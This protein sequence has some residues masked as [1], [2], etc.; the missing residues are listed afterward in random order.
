MTTEKL[1]LFLSGMAPFQSSSASGRGRHGLDLNQ[2]KPQ[3]RAMLVCV[4]VTMFYLF[5]FR[6]NTSWYLEGEGRRVSICCL[7]ERIFLLKAS[8]VAT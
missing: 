6:T 5:F 7:R 2:A 8:W 1:L 4:S 3:Q